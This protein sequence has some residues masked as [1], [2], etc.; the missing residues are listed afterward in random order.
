MAGGY[1][2]ATRI[3]EDQGIEKWW[4]KPEMVARAE[5]LDLI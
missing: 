2:A 3:A 5:E 4:K 1:N